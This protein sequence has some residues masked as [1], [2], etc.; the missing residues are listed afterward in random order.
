LLHQ[1]GQKGRAM[2]D[3]LKT[4]QG[5]A[6]R[7]TGALALLLCLSLAWLAPAALAQSPGPLQGKMFGGGNRALI[8]VLH[9]DVSKGGPADYHYDIAA[10]IAAQNKGTSVFAMLR[11][12]YGDSKGD[13]SPGSNNNR[14]DHYTKTNNSMVAKTIQ[15]LAQQ[16]G[17]SRV[18]AVGHSGGAAQVGAIIGAHP[19][20]IDSAILVSC[21]CH[22][23]QWRQARG[24]S[25]WRNS[26]S[27]H[28][29]VAKIAPG[30]R[31]IAAVG[32]ADDNTF[33]QLS[34]DYVAAAQARG[35]P[36]SF[37]PINGARHGFGGLQATVE[38]L[39]KSEV[40]K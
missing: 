26:V 7:V 40:S 17:N 24:K 3:H 27:P 36:A 14:R 10:R 37:V 12:G 15:A 31:I 29:L 22:I 34:Q 20:L 21:P 16:T 18:I 8:V 13:K 39:V 11:P 28:S 25:A 2:T 5:R 9:G 33:P 1:F 23:T 19:G 6:L 32:T 35:L 38:K 4:A 30:T